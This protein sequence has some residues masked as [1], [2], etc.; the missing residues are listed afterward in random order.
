MVDAQKVQLSEWSKKLKPEV[1]DQIDKYCRKTNLQAESG[2]HR[3]RVFCGYD[4][5]LIVAS[6]PDLDC[7]FPSSGILKT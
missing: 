2:A 4:L 3:H 5:M 7:T 6:W 1:F